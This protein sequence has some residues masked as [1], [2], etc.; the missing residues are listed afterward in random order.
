MDGKEQHSL[1]LNTGLLLI[2][3]V[4]HGLSLHAGLLL[5]TE[6]ECKANLIDL[7]TGYVTPPDI[8]NVD[9]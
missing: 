1:L 5:N 2:Y 9:A 8:V 3:C 4:T 7:L 6:V